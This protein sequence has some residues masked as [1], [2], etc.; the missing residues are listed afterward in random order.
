ML[1]KQWMKA[2]T[3]LSF[4]FFKAQI[5]RLLTENPYFL[6]CYQDQFFVANHLTTTFSWYEPDFDKIFFRVHPEHFA[7]I[8]SLTDDLLSDTKNQFQMS[9]C[10]ASYIF[11]L[12]PYMYRLHRFAF[13]ANHLSK[14]PIQYAIKFLRIELPWYT[15][16][17]SFGTGQV[18]C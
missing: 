15:L 11:H 12:Q 9:K 14:R 4:I 7:L 6:L 3:L 1:I 5:V 18:G 13:W 8:V 17:S 2:E 16:N 10:L